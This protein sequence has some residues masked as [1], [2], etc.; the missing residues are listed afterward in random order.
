MSTA[1]PFYPD[2]SNL[3]VY[4]D[5]KGKDHPITTPAQWKKRRQHILENMQL[6]M[7][8]MPDESRRVPLE[9]ETLEE[10]SLG[11]CRRLKITFASEPADRVSA[12]LFFPSRLAGK[13]PAMLCPHPSSPLG[14][15]SPAGINGYD[16]PNVHFADELA[17]RGYV[18]IAPDY[19]GYGDYRYDSY[20]NGYISATMKGIWNHMRAVDLLQSLPQV[21]PARIGSI[22][23]SL[24]GHNSIYV[25]VFDDRIK[26]V[27]SSCGFN[28]FPKYYGGNLAGWSHDGYMPRIAKVYDKN[29]A[30]MPFDFPDLIAALAPRAFFTNSPVDDSN[31]EVSGVRD[32]IAAAG[33][34]YELLG[35][36]DKLVAVYPTGGHDFPPEERS[37]A[38]AWLDR[39]FGR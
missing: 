1:P 16:S 19:P 24:G 31:F 35:A 17:R 12:Y 10:V 28:A 9:M 18:T 30:K 4:K 32:C 27:I 20:A 21:D 22:G 39:Q 38:Y 6:V 34:V 25:S 29:P 2:H 13:A 5:A 26:A 33:P 37:A 7:G 11:D 15:D 36:A 8:P 3:L 23:H 14:K